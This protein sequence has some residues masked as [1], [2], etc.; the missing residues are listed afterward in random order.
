MVFEEGLIDPFYVAIDALILAVQIELG[1]V[2]AMRGNSLVAQYFGDDWFAKQAAK[3]HAVVKRGT[4]QAKKTLLAFVLV[5]FDQIASLVLLLR[6]AGTVPF[7]A[8]RHVIERNIIPAK[9]ALHRNPLWQCCLHPL[10]LL[11]INREVNRLDFIA[12]IERL[13][14]IGFLGSGV[15]RLASLLR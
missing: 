1:V 2:A 14:R 11:R 4:S 5:E 12:A 9:R 10:E 15:L 3:L 8:N 7:V 6:S 13:R